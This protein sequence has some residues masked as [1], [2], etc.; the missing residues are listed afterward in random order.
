VVT[1]EGQS[2]T[3]ASADSVFAA[4][5]ERPPAKMGAGRRGTLANADG[6]VQPRRWR[7]NQENFNKITRCDVVYNFS[8][9]SNYARMMN[10]KEKEKEIQRYV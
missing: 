5:K 9:S 4:G 3:G 7:K 2:W 1:T 10:P 8:E 6:N